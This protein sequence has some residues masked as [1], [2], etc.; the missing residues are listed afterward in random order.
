MMV[1]RRANDIRKA[2]IVRERGAMVVSDTADKV[3]QVEALLKEKGVL[4]GATEPCGPLYLEELSRAPGEIR[5]FHVEG[6]SMKTAQTVLRT[7]YDVRDIRISE[8]DH[9]LQITAAPPILA[10]SEALL[11]ELRLLSGTANP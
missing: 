9:T 5:V 8:E 7:M 2:V 6:D 10:S 3:G 11:K 1:A 4:A